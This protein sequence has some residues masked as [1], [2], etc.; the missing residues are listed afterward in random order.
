[1]PIFC[2]FGSGDMEWVVEDHPGQISDT[3]LTSHGR[4]K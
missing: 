3:D 2:S 4:K 1:M